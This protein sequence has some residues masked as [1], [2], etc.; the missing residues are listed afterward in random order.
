MVDADLA[1]GAGGTT[2]WERCALGLPSIVTAVAENQVPIDRALHEQGA[3][4]YL[5]HWREVT[6]EALAR[7]LHQFLE[8]PDRLAACAQ[9]AWQVTDGLGRWRMAEALVPSNR[10]DLT[11]RPARRRDKALYWEWANDPA[12][13]AHANEPAPIS[14]STHDRW[15]EQ[16]L[17]DPETYL[18]VMVTPDQLP[19]GQVRVEIQGN[20]AVL[21]YSV[22]PAFRGRGW[23]TRLLELAAS[24]WQTVG[25]P[26]PLS[27][28]VQFQNEASC[29]AF[30]RAGFLEVEPPE[31]GGGRNDSSAYRPLGSWKLGQ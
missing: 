24:A 11:L 23:G 29:R 4:D 20:E 10:A 5:G 28:E 9:N 7:A 1:L 19:V 6:D 8:H 26:H 30:L 3:I 12:T 2:T 16:Q 22:D 31:N 17:A 15:F 25:E 21:S 13:R 27:G 14:W 18:W